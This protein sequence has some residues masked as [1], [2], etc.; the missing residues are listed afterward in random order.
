MQRTC[1][2]SGLDF[3]AENVS[4]F[5]LAFSAENESLFWLAFCAENV[6][7]FWLCFLCREC[8]FILA[9]L[10]V[11]ITC[12]YSGLAFSAENMSLFWLGF[13]CRERV[14]ILAGFLCRERVFILAWLSV[15]RIDSE[16]PAHQR[17]DLLIFVA[18]MADIT[19]LTNVLRQ[20][21]AET[22][23]SELA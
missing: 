8:V 9:W 1:L 21:G 13:Q 22:K 2:Y 15:Q 18:G 4:L 20:Y 14:F 12:L 6:S 23:R 17:G 19:A 10:S 16:V 3:S 11:Q 5:W 7:L